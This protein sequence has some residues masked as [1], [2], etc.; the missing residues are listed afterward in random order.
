MVYR[1]R[2]SDI[3]QPTHDEL[4]AATKSSSTFVGIFDKLNIKLGIRTSKYKLL[5]ERLKLES[6]N[7]DHITQGRASNKGRKF[8]NNKG[9]KSLSE[10]LV[11]NSTYSKR[12]LKSRILAKGLLT[13]TCS[14][15]HCAPIWEN[16]PLTLQLDHINGISD[17]N[18]I[19]NLRLLCP[20]CHSQTETYAGRNKKN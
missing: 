19:E 5:K 3:W 2:T 16:K 4:E 13:N 11:V 12:N 7:T 15:C 8:P 20:N 17:D 14:I 6:I 18:R 10:I 9:W 1:K